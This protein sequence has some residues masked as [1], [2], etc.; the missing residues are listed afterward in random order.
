MTNR[1]PFALASPSALCVPSAPTFSVGIGQLEV[2]DRARRAGPVQ[3]EVHRA[4]DVDVVGDVV[5]D[6]RRNRGSARCAMFADVA[7]QQVVDA[8]DRVVAVEQ[9]LGEMGADEAGGAGND[10][11]V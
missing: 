9:R 6:E 4:V 5:L 10:D 1:A 7:R 11:R 3:H 8:D 2:V